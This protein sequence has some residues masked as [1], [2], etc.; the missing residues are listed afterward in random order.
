MLRCAT[1]I[2]TFEPISVERVRTLRQT[3]SQYK[4][5]GLR[6]VRTVKVK[7]RSVE[8]GK[9]NQ[10]GTNKNPEKRLTARISNTKIQIN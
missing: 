7:T 5:Q 10:Q 8:T 4:T 1:Q 2:A 6:I 9:Q 3:L